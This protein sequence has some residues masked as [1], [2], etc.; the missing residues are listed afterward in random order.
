MGD[1]DW[2]Q[3]FLLY[4]VLLV[5][6]VVHEASHAWVAFLGGDRT[7]YHGGQVTLNPIPH[8]QRSPFGT[9]ILPLL[10]LLSTNGTAIA[11]FA[12]APYDPAWAARH[13]KRAAL[14][15][16]AGPLSNILL[17]LLASLVLI[18]L[19]R[20]TEMDDYDL[21]RVLWNWTRS[22]EGPVFAAALIAK[23]F[24]FLNVL[25]A[26]LN[27]F[28]WPPLDGASVLEGF[29]PRQLGGFFGYLRYQPIL[30]LLGFIVVWRVL[31]V[32]FI[33]TY[34]AIGDFL[35]AACR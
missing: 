6:L 11:G 34:T 25:L 31:Y 29:F 13:P 19:V 21:Q 10:L 8:I 20:T 23:T 24:V 33:P 3:V 35:V 32:I 1:I 14:M 16:L 27:L 28:P 30:M 5:S 17:V 4:T 12:S 9:V 2:I 22:G 15:A 7:A 26:L 18:V